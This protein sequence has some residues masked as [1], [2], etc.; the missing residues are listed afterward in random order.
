MA[1]NEGIDKN[2]L[3][4]F[5][6]KNNFIELS[7]LNNMMIKNLFYPLYSFSEEKNKKL[8]NNI[9]SVLD[10]EGFLTEQNANLYDALNNYLTINTLNSKLNKLDLQNTSFFLLDKSE[11]IFYGLKPTN[12][13]ISYIESSDL[14][15]RRFFKEYMK[16][17]SVKKGLYPE[18]FSIDRINIYTID[19]NLET[20]AY[21]SYINCVPV[22]ISESEVNVLGNVDTPIT[23]V[24]FNIDNYETY[25][26]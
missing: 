3:S 20:V 11:N 23:N 12:V 16:N 7:N 26:I 14:F 17:I 1:I 22:S 5:L 15:I 8:L 10:K 24:T 2:T 9:F 21:E 13:T 25:K 18:E 19:S 4:E 6:N